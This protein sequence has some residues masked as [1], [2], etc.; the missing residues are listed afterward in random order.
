MHE[1]TLR[2]ASSSD[3][4]LGGLRREPGVTLPPWFTKSWPR[5]VFS[6]FCG[7][8]GR[9]MMC[10]APEVPVARRGRKFDE[11][12][13]GQRRAASSGF[14]TTYGSGEGV[15][16]GVEGGEGAGLSSAEAR[17]QVPPA[18]A[19]SSEGSRALFDS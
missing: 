4:G 7:D 1:L 10:E 19:P 18:G 17:T 11:S 5:Q 14:R 12:G 3:P 13:R 6:R 9:P 15:G 8:A 2:L 16:L